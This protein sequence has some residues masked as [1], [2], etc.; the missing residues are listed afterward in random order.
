MKKDIKYE[1]LS[2]EIKKEI[3]KYYNIEKEK[4]SK[5][6]FGNAMVDW[7]NDQFDQWITKKYNKNKNSNQRQHYRLDIELPVRIVETLIESSSEERDA[8]G[9]VG[10]I[11]NIS[12]GGLYF[13]SD[14][15]FESSSIIM[16]QIDLS[17]IDKE[18]NDIEALAMVVRSEKLKLN[19]TYGIGVMFSSIY[20]EHKENLDLFIFKNVAY[21]IYPH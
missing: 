9:F 18:L 4:N 11:L 19:N 8:I 3:N 14:Y 5:L 13:K 1:E 6:D 20:D 16:V 10:T 7:F 2:Q 21:H 17:E 15:P 12:K